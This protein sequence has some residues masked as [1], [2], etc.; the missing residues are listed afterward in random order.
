MQV[1]RTSQ[2]VTQGSRIRLSTKTT[3]APTIF[4]ISADA[5]GYEAVGLGFTTASFFK[6]SARRFWSVLLGLQRVLLLFLLQFS[7]CQVN[8]RCKWTEYQAVLCI[9]WAPWDLGGISLIF[10][11][12][13]VAIKSKVGS[14]VRWPWK[15][16]TKLKKFIHDEEILVK[17]VH[18][19]SLCGVPQVLPCVT[20]QQGWFKVPGRLQGQCRHRPTNMQWKPCRQSKLLQWAITCRHVVL[21]LIS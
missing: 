7:Q 4:D 6:K 18:F 17:V 5:A 16:A 9:L 10:L 20:S 11:W 1:D 13:P 15:A 2:A 14:W 19:L 3:V 8:R 21:S 12:F